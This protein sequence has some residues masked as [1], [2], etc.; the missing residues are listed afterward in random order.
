M[1]LLQTYIDIQ[2]MLY[3]GKHVEKHLAVLKSKNIVI[4]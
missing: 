3:Y 1:C 4:T 2:N